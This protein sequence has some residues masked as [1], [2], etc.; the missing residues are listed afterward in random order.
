MADIGAER[1]R[2]R[3][4]LA[5]PGAGMNPK[6][7]DCLAYNSSVTSSV[8]IGV[9]AH[10]VETAGTLPTDPTARG[11]ILACRRFRAADPISVSQNVPLVAQGKKE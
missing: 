5:C 10:S 8:A 9:L 3:E 1:N 2:I 4:I 6:L 11:L 7:A